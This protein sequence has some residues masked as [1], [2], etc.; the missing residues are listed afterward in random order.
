MQHGAITVR[1]CGEQE[2]RI[3]PLFAAL[4]ILARNNE[5]FASVKCGDWIGVGRSIVL[6]AMRRLR[7]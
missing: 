5:R 1:C 7:N 3:S 6:F 2:E 4:K